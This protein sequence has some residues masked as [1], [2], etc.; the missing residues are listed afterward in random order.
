MPEKFVII[1][2]QAECAGSDIYPSLAKR[3]AKK[4]A[5]TWYIRAATGFQNIKSHRK[6]CR[7]AKSDMSI[8]YEA[9]TGGYGEG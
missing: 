7:G 8:P 5:H 3:K 4:H 1:E 2:V 6:G 9:V